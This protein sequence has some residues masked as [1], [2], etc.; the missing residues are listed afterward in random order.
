MLIVLFA[1][2]LEHFI[3]PDLITIP[4]IFVGLVCA[5]GLRPGP[6][7]AAIGGLV[8]AGVL[9]LLFFAWVLFRGVE[10]LGLGDVKM[11]AMVGVF[12]GWKLTV[13]TLVLGSFLGSLVGV[14]V[15]LTGRGNMRS[16]LPFGTFLSLAAFIA[17]VCGDSI[18]AWY[19]S[20]Y[21]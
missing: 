7:D 19:R 16:Q 9:L 18:I 17:S 3:L 15:L 10:P 13:L 6:T 8:G 5:F 12:L 1:I 2:D 14:L 20:L 21:V 4:G 11:M